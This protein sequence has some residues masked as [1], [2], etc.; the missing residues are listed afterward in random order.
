MSLLHRITA[1]AAER[2]PASSRERWLE[3]LDLEHETLSP[4]IDFGREGE[5][6]LV[7]RQTPAGRLVRDRTVTREHRA[8]L[9]LQGAAAAAFF[10]ARGFPLTPEDFALAVWDVSAGSARLW[11]PRTP[12]SVRLGGHAPPAQALAALVQFLFAHGDRLAHP[13]ARALRDQLGAPDSAFK[14]GEFWVASTLRLFPE[15]AGPAA[16]AAR[17]RCMGSCGEAF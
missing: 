17:E 16:A 7:W 12:E 10:A 1:S 15:L 5:E 14:R 6:L 4:A 11:L 3:F 9:L 13:A 2:F 8:P